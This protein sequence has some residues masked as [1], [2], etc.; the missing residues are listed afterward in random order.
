M[1][2]ASRKTRW[3]AIGDAGT[4][5][6]WTSISTSSSSVIEISGSMMVSSVGA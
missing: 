3:S 6:E 2:G 5:A 4:V 1:V